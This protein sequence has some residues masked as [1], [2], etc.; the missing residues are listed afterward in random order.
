MCLHV[1]V[2]YASTD[3][4]VQKV[5]LWSC[6]GVSKSALGAALCLNLGGERQGTEPFLKCHIRPWTNNQAALAPAH[7]LVVQLSVP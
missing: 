7:T 1:N 5:P 4:P 6:R 2:Q 3:L